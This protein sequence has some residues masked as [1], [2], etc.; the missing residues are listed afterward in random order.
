[1]LKAWI[2][3]T[4]LPSGRSCSSGKPARWRGCRE[5]ALLSV[6]SSLSPLSMFLWTLAPPQEQI[7]VG[8]CEPT[9]KKMPS[10]HGHRASAGRALMTC[11]SKECKC[12]PGRA[13]QQ[14]SRVSESL[15]LFLCYLSLS[16]VKSG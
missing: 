1:M 5:A 3:Q 16:A 13:S 11:E 6:P 2:S 9:G 7:S 12:F 8:F 15:E 4:T 14:L 10:I